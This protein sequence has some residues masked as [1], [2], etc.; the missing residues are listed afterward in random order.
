MIVNHTRVNHMIVNHTRVN[1]MI[2]NHSAARRGRRMISHQQIAGLCVCLAGEN[3]GT[4]NAD[5]AAATRG[6]TGH[7]AS[8][9]AQRSAGGPREGGGSAGAGVG[10]H[11][12]KV[13]SSHSSSATTV[14]VRAREACER[15]A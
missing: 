9:G 5:N 11:R 6:H 1:H 10:A 4:H 3:R 14:A 2:V 7:A 13:T 12:S 15:Q 8:F